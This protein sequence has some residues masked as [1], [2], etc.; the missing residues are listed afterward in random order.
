MTISIDK[1]TPLNYLLVQETYKRKQRFFCIYKGT[2]IEAFSL[3]Q[4]SIES[5]Y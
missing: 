1:L 3:I 2:Y 5:K 4:P